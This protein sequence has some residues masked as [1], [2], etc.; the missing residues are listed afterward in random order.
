MKKEVNVVKIK[1]NESSKCQG[2]WRQQQ[3]EVCKEDYLVEF[4]G[5]DSEE[6]I[7]P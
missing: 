2:E 1:L 3:K 4:P 6:D 7:T 5:E